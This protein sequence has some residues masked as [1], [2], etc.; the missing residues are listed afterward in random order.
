MKAR[1]ILAGRWITLQFNATVGAWFIQNPSQVSSSSSSSV[2]AGAMMQFGMVNIPDGWL[3]CDGS[4]IL[5]ATYPALFT[6]IGVTWGAGN[7]S[8][9]FN[10]PDMRGY[11]TRGFG[12]NGDGTSSGAFA[13]RVVASVLQHNHGVTIHDPGHNHAASQPAHNHG[14]NDPGH[15]HPYGF[16]IVGLGVNMSGLLN[17][18]WV[19]PTGR[20]GTGITL[21]PAQPGVTINGNTTG[22][23]AT[24]SNTGGENRP[25]TIALPRAIKT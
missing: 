21:D 11:Y 1:D 18:P 17:T 3:P 22:I 6:A 2:A 9:T 23:S 10:V 24:V 4:A 8:T 7:G 14:L 12:V 13:Q 16:E 25:V 5:R 20:V 19:H 15:E